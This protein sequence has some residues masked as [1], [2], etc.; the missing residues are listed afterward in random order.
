MRVCVSAAGDTATGE[1]WYSEKPLSEVYKWL[2]IKLAEID[3][4]T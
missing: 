3:E 2:A 1:R 4:T